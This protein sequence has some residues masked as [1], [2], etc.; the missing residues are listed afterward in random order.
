MFLI[1]RHPH[2]NN[3]QE[4]AVWKI[5]CWNSDYNNLML[6]IVCP[7]FQII[8]LMHFKIIALDKLENIILKN[9]VLLKARL[10][11]LENKKIIDCNWKQ[12]EN[13]FAALYAVSHFVNDVVLTL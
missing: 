2:P 12:K 13:Y 3:N 8:I 5:I 11:H 1:L 6:A 4:K 10:Y 9:I 7:I